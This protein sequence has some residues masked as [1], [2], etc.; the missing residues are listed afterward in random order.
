MVRISL[1]L[2]LM[3]KHTPR[4]GGE[5]RERAWRQSSGGMRRPRE[6]LGQ[7]DALAPPLGGPWLN[8]EGMERSYCSVL[9]GGGA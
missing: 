9:S 6:N 7:E 1:I 2:R 5:D 4:G 3:F 8:V